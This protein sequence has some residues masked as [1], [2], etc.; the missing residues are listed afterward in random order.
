[1][2]VCLIKTWVT[3]GITTHPLAE[4]RSGFLEASITEFVHGNNQLLV[5]FVLY[6]SCFYVFV[7]GYITL[8]HYSNAGIRDLDILKA[9]MGK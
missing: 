2:T 1:M 6:R 5:S 9:V 7:K 4:P 3:V 8:H